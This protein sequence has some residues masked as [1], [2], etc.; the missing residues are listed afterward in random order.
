MLLSEHSF[1]DNV[2]V[3]ISFYRSV[4]YYFDTITETIAYLSVACLM[5]SYNSI[6]HK[7]Y[8]YFVWDREILSKEIMLE[9]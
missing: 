6:R 7:P 1:V 2:S 9:D 5:K 4:F 3:N 8:L